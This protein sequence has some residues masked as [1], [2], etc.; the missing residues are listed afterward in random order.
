MF[1]KDPARANRLL[2]AKNKYMNIDRI[3]YIMF[4]KVLNI[5]MNK[6]TP[7]ISLDYILNLFVLSF[8]QSA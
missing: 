2:N 5:S 1:E 7:L 3:G 4:M 8:D 6:P